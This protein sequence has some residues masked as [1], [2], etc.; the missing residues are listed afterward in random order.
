MQ[1]NAT[2]KQRMQEKT[3]NLQ[4]DCRPSGGLTPCH[5]IWYNNAVRC[6]FTPQTPM[7]TLYPLCIPLIAIALLLTAGKVAAQET[8][9]PL[10]SNETMSFVHV[11]FSKVEVDRLKTETKKLGE[12]L[13][14]NLGF[15]DR[16]K[17]ATL[18]DLDVELENLDE[19]IRPII[20]LVTKELGITEIAWI[21][22]KNFQDYGIGAVIVVPW[23]G[24][25]NADLQKLEAI[26]P[27]QNFYPVGDFLFHVDYDWWEQEKSEEEV[28]AEWVKNAA[29]VSNPPLLQALQRLNPSDEVKAVVSFQPIRAE[30]LSNPPPFPEEEEMSIPIQNL[31]NFVYTNIEWVAASVPVSELLFG[32]EAKDWRAV[33]VKLSSAEDAKTLREMLVSAIDEGIAVARLQAQE[34]GDEIPPLFF[35]FMKGYLRTWLPEV[36]GDTWFLQWKTDRITSGLGQ[37]G[38][39][40]MSLLSFLFVSEVREQSPG[41]PI[42]AVPVM[43]W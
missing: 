24:R 25:T 30:L 14:T 18:R 9:T 29:T 37:L 26:I 6:P 4:R 31:I 39:G 34:S 32:T 40:Y 21:I 41:Q 38:V 36:E 7:K 27:F 43:Q 22:D 35:E 1:K 17:R 28:L 15:D 23:K 12:T 10:L 33:I 42:Q 8:F 13:L 16:S 2:N 11:D 5:S 3:G 20:E 19:M